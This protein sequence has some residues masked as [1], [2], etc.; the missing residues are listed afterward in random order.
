MYFSSHE[1]TECCGCGGCQ[2]ICPLHC[3]T[4]TLLD[5]GF[6]YPE[7]NEDICVHCNKCMDVCPIHRSEKTLTSFQILNCYYGWHKDE[8]I[9]M[10]STSGGAFSAIAELVLK[11]SNSNVYGAL[12]DVDWRVCHTRIDSQN[13]LERLRQSKYVQSN[14]GN[15]YSEIRKRLN[16]H[17]NVLFCG[18]PCQVDGLRLFLGKEYKKLLLVELLCHGV[19]SPAIFKKIYT[20]F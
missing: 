8:Y 6:F 20:V 13:G 5:D 18:P 3:I 15:C 2:Q 9:R 10:K 17:E 11:N 12:Y 7:I 1:R 4:M 19:T 16:H 14:L